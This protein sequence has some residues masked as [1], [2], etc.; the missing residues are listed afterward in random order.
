MHESGWGRLDGCRGRWLGGKQSPE[1][2]MVQADDGAAGYMW[3]RKYTMEGPHRKGR[4]VAE[5]GGVGCC[6]CGG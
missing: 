2:S 1:L 3:K 6:E 5:D 4:A